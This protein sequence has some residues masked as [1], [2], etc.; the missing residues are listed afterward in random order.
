MVLSPQVSCSVP[1]GYL[2]LN[3]GPAEPGPAK[4]SAPR[5]PAAASTAI[6]R[7]K[8]NPPGANERVLT[9]FRSSPR[10]RIL[11]LPRRDVASSGHCGCQIQELR[12]THPVDKPYTAEEKWTN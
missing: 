6:R 11:L 2:F 10:V 9:P 7:F 12:G 5:R 8:G 4:A 1:V 3:S